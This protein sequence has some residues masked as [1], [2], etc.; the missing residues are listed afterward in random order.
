M[1]GGRR[2]LVGF[3]FELGGGAAVNQYPVAAYIAMVVGALVLGWAGWDWVRSYDKEPHNRFVA[4]TVE[5]TRHHLIPAMLGIMGIAGLLL[6]GAAILGAIAYSNTSPPAVGAAQGEIPAPPPPI[7]Q[8]EAQPPPP[9]PNAEREPLAALM[10]NLSG[11]INRRIVPIYSEENRL[12]RAIDLAVETPSLSELIDKMHDFSPLDN[13]ASEIYRQII[14]QNKYF[15]EELKYVLD[16]DNMGNSPLFKLA[17]L[18]RT[19][20]NQLYA[21]QGIAEKTKDKGAE[22]QL[23]NLIRPYQN[24]ILA[25]VTSLGTWIDA[26]NKRIEEQKHAR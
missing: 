25:S 24:D 1:V 9:R 26:T 6:I 8:T 10:T 22:N 16:G 21:A 20:V 23:M 15:S 3:G 5:A 11:I 2:G 19:Y 14:P 13:I 17:S 4:R 12:F 7:K 18:N